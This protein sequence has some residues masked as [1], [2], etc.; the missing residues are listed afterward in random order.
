MPQLHFVYYCHKSVKLMKLLF[1]MPRE[2]ET[3]DH[4]T[5]ACVAA[6]CLQPDA[7]ASH[8]AHTK[9]A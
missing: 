5:A 8:A 3:D 7:S 2:R 6:A 4:E 1:V 9:T